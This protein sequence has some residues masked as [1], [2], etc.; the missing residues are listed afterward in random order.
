MYQAAHGGK[1]WHT[2]E[3]VVDMTLSLWEHRNIVFQGFKVAFYVDGPVELMERD[4]S[5]INRVT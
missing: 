4:N 1:A 5:L 3:S 2:L